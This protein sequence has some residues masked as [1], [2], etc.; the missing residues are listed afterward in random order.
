MSRDIWQPKPP[1]S[2]KKYPF[3]FISDLA[4]GET[5]SAATVTATVWSGTDANP[6]AII[7]G[8]AGI[9]SPVVTQ[10]LTGGLAGNIY[11]VV[12][13]ATT[14][15]GQTLIRSAYLVISPSSVP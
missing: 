11:S 1:S 7:S 13:T 9:A 2:T 5:V 6:S 4:V 8:A 15:A 12:C 10:T 14:S 3:N